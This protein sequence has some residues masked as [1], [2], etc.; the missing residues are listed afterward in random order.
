M[1][2]NDTANSHPKY[3]LAT[4]IRI[5]PLCLPWEFKKLKFLC[6]GNTKVCPIVSPQYGTLRMPSY[7]YGAARKGRV[8]PHWQWDVHP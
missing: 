1:L 6:P 4:T 2:Q 3:S 5:I 7:H 8:S